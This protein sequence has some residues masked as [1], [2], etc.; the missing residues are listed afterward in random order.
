[1][2]FVVWFGLVHGHVVQWFPEEKVGDA[3]ILGKGMG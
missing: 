2:T 3:F 1:M